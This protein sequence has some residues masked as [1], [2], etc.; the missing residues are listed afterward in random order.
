MRDSCRLE[1]N[2]KLMFALR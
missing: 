1:E 2:D